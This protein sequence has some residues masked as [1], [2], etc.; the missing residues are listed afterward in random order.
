M[1]TR[2]ILSARQFSRPDLEK[3][4][5]SADR[6]K[7]LVKSRTIPQRNNPDGIAVLFFEAS[8]RTDSSFQFA[9]Q[10]LGIPIR[11]FTRDANVFSS[12]AK[13][14]MLEHTI[15]IFCNYP[16][17]K[18][19][20][21]RHPDDYSAE[22][23]AEV[24]D[25]F[26]ISIVNGG[27]GSHEHPTQATLDLYTMEEK[28]E[29]PL[30]K[31]NLAVAND[32]EYSRTIQSL[33]LLFGLNYHPAEIGIC[34]PPGIFLPRNLEDE[35]IREGIRIKVFHSLLDAA[36]WADFLYMTRPQIERV[37]VGIEDP[38]EKKRAI[39]KQKERFRDFRIT[40][41]LLEQI[42]PACPCKIM[43]PMPINRRDFNEIT[44]DADDHYRCIFYD[45]AANGLPIRM[46]FLDE[47]I[48][49]VAY[50]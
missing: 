43:H 18:A 35:L 16:Y 41:H 25:P 36:M 48:T 19:I 31:V 29:K 40:R 7:K 8:T 15:R 13:G 44:E 4:F 22:V 27:D 21:I 11:Y 6:M 38:E 47:L 20:V 34:A 9:A 30:S 1:K 3:L 42:P 23:A 17:L 32:I 39:E 37:G 14:E 10:C 26:G 2:H 5:A 28:T 33:L 12:A 50:A 46:A 49:N 45:Q 24:A